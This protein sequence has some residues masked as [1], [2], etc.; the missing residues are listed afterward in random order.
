M[1]RIQRSWPLRLAKQTRHALLQVK[2]ELLDIA[3]KSREIA[4]KVLFIPKARLPGES[5]R[6]AARRVKTA[7]L[8]KHPR[9]TRLRSTRR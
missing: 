2:Q 7:I 8:D 3:Y 5:N 4:S 1:I 6:S 9:L